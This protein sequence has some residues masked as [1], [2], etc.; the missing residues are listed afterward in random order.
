M[1]GDTCSIPRAFL[2]LVIALVYQT[3]PYWNWESL[4]L[5]L[6][7]F[8]KFC[9]RCYL[10][11]DLRISLYLFISPFARFLSVFRTSSVWLLHSALSNQLESKVINLL[12][13]RILSELS[14]ISGLLRYFFLA[15]LH[16]VFHFSKF[17]ASGT[18][19]C[20]V[21]QTICWRDGFQLNVVLYSFISLRVVV[22]QSPGHLQCFQE[23]LPSALL[24]FLQKA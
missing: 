12:S 14:D 16:S 4:F 11:Q 13:E 22:P 9:K 7:L 24:V 19:L 3:R 17:I 15:S 21:E 8:L 20:R 1:Y 10:R 2:R 23:A 5:G 18:T 6:L